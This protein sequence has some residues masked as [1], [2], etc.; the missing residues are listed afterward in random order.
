MYFTINMLVSTLR[1]LRLENRLNNFFRKLGSQ[2]L[3]IID[4]WGIQK[5][6]GDIQND[7]EQIIDILDSVQPAACIRLV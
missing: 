1:M 3:L 6:D 4:D 5:V 7:F 2:N